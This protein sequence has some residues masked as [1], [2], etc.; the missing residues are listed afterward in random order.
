MGGG[1]RK[2]CSYNHLKF[3]KAFSLF[4]SPDFDDDH[5]SSTR[6][7]ASLFSP[8]TTSQEEYTRNEN[9]VVAD[10]AAIIRDEVPNSCFIQLVEMKKNPPKPTVDCPKSL[11]QI[12]KDVD[13][14]EGT[15]QSNCQILLELINLPEEGRIAL[16]AATRGQGTSLE[17]KNQRVGRITASN[18]KRVFTR[19]GTCLRQPQ[20]DHDM[21]SLLKSTMGYSNTAASTYAM[22]HGI[23]TEPH[24]K[25]MYTRLMKKKHKSFFT[26]DSGLVLYSSKQY[27]AASPDLVS[28]CKC[29]GEGVVELKC[30]WTCRDATPTHE[31]YAHLVSIDGQSR[32]SP[33]SE[34]MFQMQG[35]MACMAV[36]HCDFFVFTT[37]GHHLE[38]ILFDQELWNTMVHRFEYY[39][40]NWV[41]PELMTGELS[42]TMQ[43]DSNTAD[44]SYACASAK[45]E[46]AVPAT[47]SGSVRG[48]LTR[49]Q[50]PVVYLCALCGLDCEEDA[51]AGVFENNSV[52]CTKCKS[53][54]HFGCTSIKADSVPKD[55]DTWFC[56]FCI[57]V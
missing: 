29:C 40:L 43:T 38:R 6:Y 46:K 32:L 7:L 42:S 13:A 18:M 14:S 56:N 34:Y 50:L 39:W 41:A 21:N 5:Q 19:I 8:L 55:D 16:E 17:W 28:S 35:Q 49:P 2:Y 45:T 44:H 27:I 25:H 3:K 48:I 15:L 12:A 47:S 53:W 37:H 57:P 54:W 11:V 9:R 10:L 30:P 23:A 51:G 24:A 33:T 4:C 31:N 1:G 52:E 20:A 26:R 36:G 22:K